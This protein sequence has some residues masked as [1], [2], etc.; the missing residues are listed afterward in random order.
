MELSLEEYTKLRKAHEFLVAGCDN[1][2]VMYYIDETQTPPQNSIFKQVKENI[3][4][5]FDKNR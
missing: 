4:Y 3:S 1:K 5:V 2:E